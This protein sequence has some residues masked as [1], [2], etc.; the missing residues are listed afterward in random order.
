[1]YNGDYFEGDDVSHLFNCENTIFMKNVTF[2]LLARMV[3][4]NFS[5]LV[6]TD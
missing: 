4:L 6:N 5:T 2:S 1:M 3:Y